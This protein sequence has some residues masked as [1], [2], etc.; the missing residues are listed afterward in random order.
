MLTGGKP[1]YLAAYFP[2]LLA[3]GAQPAVDWAG[4][5]H[6]RR[7]A[8]LITA[9]LVLAVLQLPVTLPALPVPVVHDTPV[10]TLNYDA[11][12]TIGWPALAAEIAAAYRSLP[13]P[14]ARPRP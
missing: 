12:E 4:R 11:G 1:Y 14:S 3:A 6:R 9:G 5:A 2:I 7:R 8:G 13:P 10:V